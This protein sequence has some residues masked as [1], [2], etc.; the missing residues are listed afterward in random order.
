MTR[1]HRLKMQEVAWSE[2]TAYCYGGE[3]CDQIEP[4][5]DGY[6]DGDK[7]GEENSD[8]IVLDPKTFPPGTRVTVSFPTCPECSEIQET[9]ECGFDWDKWVLDTYS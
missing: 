2:R 5:W 9:C 3:T 6:W 8:D 4:R 1:R 7:E